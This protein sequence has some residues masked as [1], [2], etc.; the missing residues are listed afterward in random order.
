MGA[1]AEH[2]GHHCPRIPPV[3][4]AD[5]EAVLRIDVGAIELAGAV[6][7][8]VTPDPLTRSKS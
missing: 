7:M 8:G 2:L 4:Q 5:E 3:R 6:A 1:S